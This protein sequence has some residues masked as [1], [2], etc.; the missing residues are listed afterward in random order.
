[1]GAAAELLK[2]IRV[3]R[4]ALPKIVCPVIIIY[5]TRDAAIHPD[6]A[7]R[8]FARIGARDKQLITLHESGHCI[9]V[10]RQWE[11]VA[12]QTYEFIVGHGG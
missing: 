10:D 4:R 6:S 8:T 1:M 11:F 3:V 12:E 7:Q 9:T 2:L 5:S